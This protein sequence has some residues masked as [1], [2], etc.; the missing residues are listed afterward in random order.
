MVSGREQGSARTIKSTSWCQYLRMPPRTFDTL[1]QL[2]GPHIRKKDTNFRKAISPEHRLAQTVRFLAAGETLRSSCFSFLNGRSTACGIVS[3]VCQVLWDVLGPLYVACPSSADEWLQ[4]ASDFEERWNMPHCVGAIDGKH[5][6]IEC[7]SKSGSEDYNYKNCFSKSLLAISDACYRFLYV[8]I[9][10][11]GSDSDGGVF[12]RSRLQEAI[13][14]NKQGFPPDAPLGNVGNIPFYLVGDEA[15]PLKTYMMRPYPRKSLHPFLAAST[16]EEQLHGDQGD[17]ALTSHFA[18]PH[19]K[20]IFN[21][22]LSRARRVIENAF[23]IMAQ[24]WRIL[25]RPFKAK[26]DNV[27]RIISACVVL[28]N[29][30]LKESPTSRSAYCPPGTADHL[31]W[32]GNITEGSWRA[33]DSSNTALPPLRST[34]CHSTRAAYRVRDL[35][36]KYFVTDGKIPWQ[37]YMIKDRTLCSGVTGSGDAPAP[38]SSS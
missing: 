9:G 24:K 7:P 4:I 18:E 13:L 37:E 33:E 17:S 30:L 16:E 21:Y 14:S 32:Q 26:D 1:V 11:H 38:E 22:R 3:S 20:R 6:A 8:E 5:V 2:V 28:H 15:F 19:S 36:A 27:R 34:G 10:H 35:L 23:G 12:S 29:F 31:D 25:R